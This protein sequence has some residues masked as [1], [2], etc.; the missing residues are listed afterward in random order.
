MGSLSLFKK[1]RKRT[2][3]WSMITAFSILALMSAC[4]P[5]GGG[6]DGGPQPTNTEWVWVSGSNHVAQAGAYGT[7]G[8]GSA[9]NTPGARGYQL[10]W[11]D[12]QARVW[13]FAG[14]GYDAAGANGHLNDVWRYTPST[15]EWAWMAGADA[16]DQPG[17]YGTLGVAAP[18]NVPGSRD[19]CATWLDASGTFWVFGGFGFDA[20]G[21]SGDLNDLWK[22][23]PA[24]LEWT[25]MS[26]GKTLGASGV[27]GT[28]GVASPA[29]IPGARFGAASWMDSSGNM[30]LFGGH[31]SDGIGTVGELSDVWKYDP[32]ADEWT[33]MSGSPV[34]D[35][36]GVYGTKGV[37]SPA[38]TPGGRN[39]SAK[40][41]DSTGKL[42]IFGGAGYDAAGTLGELSDL[43]KFDPASLEWTW[44]AGSDTADQ[45][46]VY[47]TRGTPAASNAP[48]GNNGAS[49]WLDSSGKMWMFAGNGY[50]E[51]TNLGLLNDLWKFDPATLQWTWLSGS[52]RV[53]D[54]G[55]YGVQGERS[56]ENFPGGRQ[57]STIWV[58][59]EGKL[60][61]FGGKGYDASGDK[62]ALNDLWNYKK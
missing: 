27:Y 48:G 15:Q 60:W 3:L 20:G 45:T 33:W 17:V 24:T 36:S 1:E 2:A 32:V 13:I 61:V 44:T 58:D 23:D 19:T 14:H 40:W 26:G 29:N 46:A 54:A 51:T 62:D 56:S 55:E 9:S 57:F 59:G 39:A 49:A 42:W 11:I 21:F 18:A 52:K 37:A 53:N 30:W 4:A 50:A 28:M 43:W 35:Q 25:W 41:R 16:I 8:T 7:L 47:G 22:F 34:A 38:N 31:G 6:D 5:G 10:L 12:S